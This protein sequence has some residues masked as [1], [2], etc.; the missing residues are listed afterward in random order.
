LVKKRVLK[1]LGAK[2]GSTIR[3][4]YSNIYFKLKA[5]RQCNNCGSWSLKRLASGIWQCSSCGLKVAGDAY[6]L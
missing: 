4:R 2:Y 5:K 6:T 3:K 1:G